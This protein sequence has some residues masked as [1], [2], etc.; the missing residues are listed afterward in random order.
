MAD[1]P[2]IEKIKNLCFNSAGASIGTDPHSEFIMSL[3]FLLRTNSYRTVCE[4]PIF[5]DHRTLRT[6]RMTK[7]QGYIDL[8]ATGR[9]ENIAIEFDRHRSLKYKSIEKLLQFDADILI[10]IVGNGALNYNKERIL[11]VMNALE[12][13]DRKV[14]IIAMSEKTCEEVNWKNY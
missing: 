7:Q 8:F 5:F 4:S 2:I 13:T 10:G 11:E 12:I 6:G 14:L 9:N 3:E 1:E